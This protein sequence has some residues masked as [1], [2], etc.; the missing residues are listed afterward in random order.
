MATAHK[1]RGDEDR[2]ELDV[3]VDAFVR[4]VD[5]TIQEARGK[6]S[7]AELKKADEEARAILNRA[8]VAA[9]SS[10]HRA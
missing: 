5:S 6:M 1:P 3:E 7:D 9:R 2:E 4:K 8:S 10:R